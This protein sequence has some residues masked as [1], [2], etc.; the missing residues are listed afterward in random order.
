MGG[1]GHRD[2]CDHDESY[3][4]NE[5]GCECMVSLCANCGENADGGNPGDDV[6]DVD[7]EIPPLASDAAAIVEGISWL[8]SSFPPLFEGDDMVIIQREFFRQFLGSLLCSILLSLHSRPF[9]TSLHHHYLFFI[10]L[11]FYGIAEK[12]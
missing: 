8:W 11:S 7:E 9:D 4:S 1:R 3:C 10:S 5:H 12:I 2:S 6:G